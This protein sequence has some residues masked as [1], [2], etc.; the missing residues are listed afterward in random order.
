[1]ISARIAV[2]RNC[3]ASRWVTLSDQGDFY[4]VSANLSRT[5]SLTPETYQ[6]QLRS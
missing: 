6:R 3:L 4:R 1:M 2:R 5:S